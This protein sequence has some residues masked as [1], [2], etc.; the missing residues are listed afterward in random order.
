MSTITP[1]FSTP[2]RI[3]TRRSVP[4][5]RIRAGAAGFRKCADRFIKRSRRQISE[6]RHGLSAISLFPARPIWA[7][8]LYRPGSE[9]TLH[10]GRRLEQPARPGSP[11]HAAGPAADC[12]EGGDC[13]RTGMSAAI[14][15]TAGP[16]I[17]LRSCG[18]RTSPLANAACQ[19]KLGFGFTIFAGTLMPLFRFR[20][21]CRGILF[22]FIACHRPT[23]PRSREARADRPRWRRDRLPRRDPTSQPPPSGHR[24]ARRPVTTACRSTAFWPT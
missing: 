11:M 15:G 9:A 12:S 16:R 1:G 5:A 17:S 23:G 7:L 4:P 14:C 18:L 3:C 22:P 19:S 20:S 24:P 21:C 13:T 8:A 2:D 10:G 6:F